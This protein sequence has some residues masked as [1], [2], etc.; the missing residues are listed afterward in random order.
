MY[1]TLT[2]DADDKDQE[3]VDQ[4]FTYLTSFRYPSDCPENRKRVIRKKAKRFVQKNGEF[5][6][7]LKVKSK[8]L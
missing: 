4:A 3:L 5:F 8:V 7:K 6:Y 2:M 1:S